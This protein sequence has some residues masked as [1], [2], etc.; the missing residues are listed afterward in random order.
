MQQAQAAIV[1]AVL[2]SLG[3]AVLF[4][5]SCPSPNP[6]YPFWLLALTFRSSRPAFCG[7]LTS[8]VRKKI[9]FGFGKK[10]DHFTSLLE[11]LVDDWQMKTRYASAFLSAYRSDISALHDSG[12]KRLE[13]SF[14]LS[15][16]ENIL[17]AYQM[18]DLRAFAIVGQAYKAYLNDLRRGKY[19]GTEVEISIWA[20]LSN[21]S[22]LVADV[23]K[24]FAKYIED[25]YEKKFPSLFE[26]VFS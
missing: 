25:N 19:V 3:G 20:I 24:A 17:L 26:E 1:L 16:K 22:D 13:A 18:P 21:R 8:P 10:P 12:L 23:D 15:K 11:Y 5:S 6:G 4:R 2:R 7:R 9:M 14:D